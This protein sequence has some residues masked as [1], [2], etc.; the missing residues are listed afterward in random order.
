MVAGRVALPS[1]QRQ[2]IAVMKNGRLVPGS[3]DGGLPG[4]SSSPRRPGRDEGLHLKDAAC[5]GPGHFGGLRSIS[6]VAISRSI[7]P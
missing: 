6:M 5:R 7:S 2:S 4:V 3:G 1:D